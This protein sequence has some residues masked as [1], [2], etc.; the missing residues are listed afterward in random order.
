MKDRTF[1]FACIGLIFTLSIIFG[2]WYF[3]GDISFNKENL[4]DIALKIF[5]PVIS[6]PIIGLIISTIIITILQLILGKRI[7]FDK[8]SDD[9][10][11][12]YLKKIDTGLTGNFYSITNENGQYEFS[13][14][15][16][17][18][19][20]HQVLLRKDDENVQ[21]IEYSTRRYD[22]FWTHI[23]ISFSILLGLIIGLV[24]R[25]SIIDNVEY[26]LSCSK[27]F[28]VLPIIL[29]VILGLI[30]GGKARKEANKFEKMIILNK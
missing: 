1:I 12:D 22:L 18:Y 8:P 28:W 3:G 4:W 6:S 14:L 2:F 15:S 25:C 29:Y 21:S 19:L 11:N 7:E 17:L 5:I 9:I 24:I 26:E 30:H 16:K 23:N 20:A 13:D 27:L 10:K